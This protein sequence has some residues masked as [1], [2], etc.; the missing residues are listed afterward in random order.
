MN[1]IKKVVCLVFCC[2]CVG[3][4]TGIKA[5]QPLSLQ[6]LL[7]A[8]SDNYELLKRE[9]SLV[10]ARQAAV[11]ATKYDRLP[12]LTGMLQA[13]INSDN[14]L[15]GSYQSYGMIPSVVSGVRAQ[16]NLSP[17]AGDAAIL[18]LNWEAVNFGAYKAREDLSKSDLQ[19][20]MNTLAT[21]QYNLQGYA[22]AY[23]LELIRQFELQN[24]QQNNVVRL[25]QLKTTIDA[26]VRNGVR[27]GV[28]S[29]VASAELSK[30]IIALYQA[31]KNLAQTKVQLSNLTGLAAGQLNPDT[32]SENK[33]N[34]DGA[35]FVFSITAETIHHPY[36][37][38]YSSVYDQSRA[39]LLLEKKSYY[40]KI[41]L[42]ADA[43][44]RGSSLSNTDQYN[45]ELLQGYQ[46]SRFN[47][48]VGL[49]MTYNI[50]NI[51]HKKLN[52]NIYR[53]QS[54][55]AYHQLQNEKANLSSDVQQALLEKDF[56]HNRLVETRH[57]LDAAA[58]AYSQQLSLYTNGL[59]S[60]IELN[61][62]QDY[63]IQAQRDYVEAKV[64]LMKSVINY[65][66]VTNTF[67]ALLQTIKL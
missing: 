36:I 8:M 34:V 12:Q 20:Q 5:E 49:T 66:L 21:T 15:E 59:S 25:Q 58:S 65:S 40:P 26:L 35:A 19:V 48:L 3:G 9:G 43:W 27:P 33:V 1:C 61:T 57:Q 16:S 4:A 6:Q 37:N 2:T 39:R 52:S 7:N 17:V 18:D 45:S 22:S 64:G 24:V 42:D 55:A 53:F 46:P 56:Q 31:Q 10:Q 13:T 32:A 38:L 14:N 30:S 63:F 23:Y 29:S 54:E 11:K 41:F 67:A 47:Y 44:G 28:D 50:L 60:I 51:A 62:A